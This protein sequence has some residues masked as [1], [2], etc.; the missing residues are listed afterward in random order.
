LVAIVA[1]AFYGYYSRGT[2]SQA[3]VSSQTGGSMVS[4]VEVAPQHSDSIVSSAFQCDGRK[5]CSQMT[6][7]DE[8]TFFLRN[9]PSVE[10]DGNRDGVPCEQQWCN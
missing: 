6:S 9:C 4:R 7:C 3:E 1:L 2:V 8:A 10:M 5:Y